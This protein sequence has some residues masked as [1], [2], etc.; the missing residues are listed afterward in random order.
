MNEKYFNLNMKWTDIMAH[1]TGIGWKQETKILE[2]SSFMTFFAQQSCY[3]LE[4]GEVFFNLIMIKGEHM[5]ENY[6]DYIF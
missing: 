6:N 5:F 4:V 3:W 2:I 1:R